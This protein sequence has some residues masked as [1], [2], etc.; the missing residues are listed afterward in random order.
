MFPDTLSVKPII[1]EYALQKILYINKANVPATISSNPVPDFNDSFS[2]N[3]IY[4]NAIVTRILSL[5]IG[6]TTLAGPV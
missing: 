3:T 6:T 1:D 5:S 4:E 2:W